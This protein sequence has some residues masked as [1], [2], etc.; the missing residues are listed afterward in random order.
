MI[1]RSSLFRT[2]FAA[3]ALV[4]TAGAVQAQAFDDRNECY[5]R[6]MPMCYQIRDVDG[7]QLCVLREV[8]SCQEKVAATGSIIPPTFPPPTHVPPTIYGGGEA[9]PEASSTGG[10]T[11]G[12]Q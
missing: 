11:T 5:N 7:Q 12:R 10:G 3:V 6:I 2:V 8:N 9:G 1:R 4:V